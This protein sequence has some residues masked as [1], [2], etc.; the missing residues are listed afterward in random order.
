[1]AIRKSSSSGIPFGNTAGRPANPGI[2]QLYSNGQTARLEL[3][4]QDSGWQNIVQETPGVASISGTYNE[5]TGSGTFTISGTNFV[6]GGIAYAVGTNAVEYQAQTTT[7]NSI[8]QM[9]AT[10]TGLSAAYEPYDIKVINPSN[11]FGLLPDAFYINDSP[12]WSTSSGSLGS[13]GA[14]SVSYQLSATDDESNNLTYT[15]VSGSLPTGLSLSSS[16]LISGT[17]SGTPGSTYTFTVSVSDGSNTAVTRSFS[18][19]IPYPVVTGGTLSSDSTY[20]YRTF[21]GNGSLVISNNT[22]EVNSLLI[23]GGGGGAGGNGSSGG[24]GAGGVFYNTSTCIAATYP[25]VVG[26]AGAGGN[27]QGKTGSNGTNS[28]FNSL[29]AIGG[30][31]GG[32]WNDNNGGQNG[33]SGGGA[34][35]IANTAGSGVSGQGYAGGLGNPTNPYPGGGG[36]G[37]GAVGGTGSGNQSGNGGAGTISYSSWITAISSSMSG[38]SGWSTATSAGRIA[39]GGAGG[40]EIEGTGGQ[41]SGGGAG[42]GGNRGAAQNGSYGPTAGITNTGSGGGS[43]GMYIGTYIYGAS[44]GSGLCIFR[45]TKASVGG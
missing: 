18:M 37:S 2:G 14:G 5:S 20:Y 7:Y 27:G 30:G 36:G 4:T 38:V 3:Y 34:G 42:G 17:N 10:F 45:Y 26:A 15:L 25:V 33:G 13:Y 44:G 28:T 23:A 41:G 40:S 32:G 39:G 35:G 8:V 21:T 11:L 24:G 12:V 6:S 29:S 43:A 16:G 9:T 31:G 1:M 19:A 22:L